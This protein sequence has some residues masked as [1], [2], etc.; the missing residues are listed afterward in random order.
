MAYHTNFNSSIR[1]FHKKEKKHLKHYF[2]YNYYIS[3]TGPNGIQN[4]TDR[5]LI[6]TEVPD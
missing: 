3:S 5:W 1:H 2:D 6:L 4:T